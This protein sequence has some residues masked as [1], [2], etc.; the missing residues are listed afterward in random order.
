MGNGMG[1]AIPQWAQTFN[2]AW[3]RI[4]EKDGGD[5]CLMLLSYAH[6]MVE[7]PTSTLSVS[8]HSNLKKINKKN[9]LSFWSQ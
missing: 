2:S 6:K 5:D 3:G 7:V 1:G 8:N 9:F 4:P